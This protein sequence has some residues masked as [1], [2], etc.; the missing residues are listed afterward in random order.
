MLY[1]YTIV[2]SAKLV[3]SCM[4][5]GV[6]MDTKRGYQTPFRLLHNFLFPP[7][8]GTAG[9]HAI[10]FV[11]LAFDISS[12]RELRFLKLD[13]EYHTLGIIVVQCMLLL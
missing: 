7:L 9:T 8:A 3:G 2:H 13:K 6:C 10:V 12:T 11:T 1:L 4:L 5:V